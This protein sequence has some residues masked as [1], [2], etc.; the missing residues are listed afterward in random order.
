M[1]LKYV[2]MPYLPTYD[3]VLTYQVLQYIY[4]YYY[5]KIQ[6]IC[7]MATFDYTKCH[8][9]RPYKWIIIMNGGD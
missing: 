4:Y 7:H 8:N 1:L 6:L 5:F 9:L 2:D 3:Y